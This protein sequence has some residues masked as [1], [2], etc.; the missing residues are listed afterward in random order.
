[1]YKLTLKKSAHGSVEGIPLPYNQNSVRPYALVAEA[2]PVA[3]KAI[4]NKGML[5]QGWQ[6]DI[7][8]LEN[9]LVLSV[10]ED[11]F[12][13]PVF[14]SGLFTDD[15]ET[16]DFS[17]LNWKFSGD[18]HWRIEPQGAGDNVTTVIR[19]GNIE[20]TQTSVL[21]LNANFIGG[22]AEFSVRVDSE[23]LWD[24]FEFIVDGKLINTW[25]GYSDW[26]LFGVELAKGK[27]HLEWRYTK[28]FANHAGE[29]TVWLDDFRLP[30]SV[31]ASLEVGAAIN[32]LIIRGLAGHK[33][34]LEIS[35]DLKNWRHHGSVVLDN[36]GQA[37]VS[38]E[39]PQG[40]G[41]SAYYRAVA[42]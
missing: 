21:S 35:N 22:R 28:D 17:R 8:S 3:L 5:F 31:S 25:S 33:Y 14:V 38:I 40:R 13:E 7:A 12:L 26:E 20:D 27:H 19:S 16:G 2:S 24:K 15:F 6:G 1:M 9:P 34:N 4:P 42:P 39:L 32:Q 30:L 10:T 37:S 11:I 29:D 23:E 18:V 41:Q 36:E